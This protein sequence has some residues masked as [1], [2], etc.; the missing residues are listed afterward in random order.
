MSFTKSRR[1]TPRSSASAPAG[2]SVSTACSKSSRDNSSRL[3]QYSGPRRFL[4]P[5]RFSSLVSVMGVLGCGEWGVGRGRLESQRRSIRSTPILSH[6]PHPTPHPLVM[7]CRATRQLLNVVLLHQL[8]ADAL[9]VLRHVR[10]VEDLAA[11]ADE[12]LRRAMA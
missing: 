3:R 6:S 1:S 12:L 7:T 9:L 10:H 4:K 8:R 11:R 5:A 2:N